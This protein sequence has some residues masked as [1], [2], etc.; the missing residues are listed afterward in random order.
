[1]TPICWLVGVAGILFQ[2]Y[3]SETLYGIDGIGGVFIYP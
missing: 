3:V 2:Y 1:M